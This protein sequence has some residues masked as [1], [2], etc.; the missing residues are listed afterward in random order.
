MPLGSGDGLSTQTSDA[1]LSQHDH[2]Y[3]QRDVTQCRVAF[4][5]GRKKSGW[6]RQDAN[7]VQCPVEPVSERSHCELD[8]WREGILVLKER[9]VC[10]EHEGESD[11]RAVGGELQDFLAKATGWE[12]RGKGWLSPCRTFLTHNFKA[13]IQ[14]S[15]T[16]LPTLSMASSG[17]DA[18]RLATLRTRTAVADCRGSER[19]RPPNTRAAASV[20][21]TPLDTAAGT[22]ARARARASGT[23]RLESAVAAPVRH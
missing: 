16:L 18:A 5:H 20:S 19:T 2:Y 21:C 10:Y 1:Y 3:R 6:A 15:Y 22:A 11:H 8:Q 13:H 12:A 4:T 17:S 23:S 14:S 9:H 7:S